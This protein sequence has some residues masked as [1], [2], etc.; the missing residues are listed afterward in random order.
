MQSTT[1][2]PTSPGITIRRANE[3]GHVNHGWLDTHHTFS[4][5]SYFDPRFTGFG[6]L[7]VLNEDIVA[8]AR[9]FGTHGHR[10]MEIVSYPVAGALAHRDSTGSGG[11]IE[12]GEVQVMSAGRGIT[13]SEMNANQG[14]QVHFLQIWI[15]PSKRQTE[16]SY[17][18]KNFGRSGGATLVVSPDGRD[19]SLP[20][21]QDVDIYRLLF[22]DSDTWKLRVRRTR[23]W[24]Q[25]IEGE[26]EVNGV[27]L[28]AGDGAALEDPTTIDFRAHADVEALVFDLN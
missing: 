18:Q 5:A 20:I 24:V 25:V 4:F 23:V 6:D 17:A 13:H 27:R 1:T 9:G 11:V 21:G 8:P 15:E 28:S 10:N 19:E 12:S 16:P 26:L 7:R 14:T 3:R 2:A 22:E